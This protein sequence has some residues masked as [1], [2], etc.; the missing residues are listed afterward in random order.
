MKLGEW[1]WGGRGCEDGMARV[2]QRHAVK[3]RAWGGLGQRN[4]SKMGGRMVVSGLCLRVLWC[5]RF[6]LCG[7]NVFMCGAMVFR[8]CL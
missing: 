1:T 8:L 7:V 3:I 5:L 2:G 6:C 4:A